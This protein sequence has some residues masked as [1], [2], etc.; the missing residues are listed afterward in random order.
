MILVQPAVIRP[1]VATDIAGE[2]QYAPSDRPGA[3][4]YAAFR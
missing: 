4:R 2:T 3:S 1:P